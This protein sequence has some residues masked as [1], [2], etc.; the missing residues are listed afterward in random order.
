MVD[1]NTRFHS[2]EGEIEDLEDLERGM[3][4]IVIGQRQVDGALYAMRVAAGMGEN[5][6]NFEIKAAGS[7]V[8]LGENSL[9]IESPDGQ[10]FTFQVDEQTR[11]RGLG[12]V[13]R[14]LADLEVGG[15]ALIGGEELEDG[16]L[17][18]RVILAGRNRNP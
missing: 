15:V 16:T 13:V 2:Q 17:L 9:T 18:A 10:Q 4:A 14:E 8:E 6:P 7:I 1:Q 12:G 11:F 5:L 3:L